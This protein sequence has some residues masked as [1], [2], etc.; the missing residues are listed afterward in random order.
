MNIPDTALEASQSSLATSYARFRSEMGQISQHS[1]VFFAGTLFTVGARYL[2]KIYLARVLGA[3]ALGMYTFGMTIV[4][5]FGLFNGLGLPQE[6]LAAMGLVPEAGPGNSRFEIVNLGNSRPV[7][8]AELVDLLEKVAAKLS[9]STCLSN[10]ETYRL[11]GLIS[12][13]L[14]VSWGIVLFSRLKKG[15]KILLPG[16][17][18][19]EC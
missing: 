4:G 5:F 8:L 11:L 6:V 9:A 12:Q 3:D 14:G 2:F 15:W 13:R 10:R 1:A 7:T 16:S 19:N 17:V 18:G